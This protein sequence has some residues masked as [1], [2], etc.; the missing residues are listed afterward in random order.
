LKIK[1]FKNAM[2]SLIFVFPPLAIL[3][4]L[5]YHIKAMDACIV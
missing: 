5:L 4:R 2:V 3:A 1:I